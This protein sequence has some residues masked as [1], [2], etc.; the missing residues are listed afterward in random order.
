L[1]RSAEGSEP[2]KLNEFV[3]APE[4]AQLNPL[5][6]LSSSFPSLPPLEPLSYANVGVRGTHMWAGGKDDFTVALFAENCIEPCE[7]GIALATF[8]RYHLEISNKLQIRHLPRGTK[9]TWSVLHL[10]VEH[11]QQLKAS[12]ED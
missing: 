11:E 3:N 6:R 10:A 9:N 12:R 2:W 7:H 4:G 5:R 1:N 8:V